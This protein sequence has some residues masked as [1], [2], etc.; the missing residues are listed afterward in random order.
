MRN[1]V[2]N[3]TFFLNNLWNIKEKL[4]KGRLFLIGFEKVMKNRQNCLA[5]TLKLGNF[6]EG[7]GGGHMHFSDRDTSPK[8]NFKYQKSGMARNSNP[9]KM[10]QPK[11]R[12]QKMALEDSFPC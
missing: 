9:Q 5:E 8:A 4:C 2:R 1:S 12:I 10:E 6:L 11:I 3:E 7:G